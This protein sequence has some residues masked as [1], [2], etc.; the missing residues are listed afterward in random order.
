MRAM[1]RLEYFLSNDTWPN[2]FRNIPHIASLKQYTVL[3][4]NYHSVL[5]A[6]VDIFKKEDTIFFGYEGFKAI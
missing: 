3:I 6:R 5:L 4:F 1:Y 2:P